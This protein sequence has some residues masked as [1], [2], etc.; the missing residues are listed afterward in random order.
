MIACSL[1]F[2]TRGPRSGEQ[3]RKKSEALCLFKYRFLSFF[4]S[5]F[6]SKLLNEGYLRREDFVIT[7]WFNMLTI[8][9]HSA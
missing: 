7:K 8:I 4:P 1:V 3:L 2:Q 5:L 9:L 6:V